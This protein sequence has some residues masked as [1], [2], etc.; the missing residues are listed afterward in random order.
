MNLEVE[1][2]L[3]DLDADHS[4]IGRVLLDV[5]DIFLGGTPMTVRLCLFLLERLGGGEGGGIKLV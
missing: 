1:R 4:G 3:E 5:L 2:L